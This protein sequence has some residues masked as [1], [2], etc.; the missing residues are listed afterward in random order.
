MQKIHANT[1]LIIAYDRGM[2]YITASKYM[3]PGANMKKWFQ[4]NIAPYKTALRY[5][6]FAAM[7]NNYPRLIVCGLAF[8]DIMCYHKLINGYIEEHTEFAAELRRHVSM[9]VGERLIDIDPC[10]KNAPVQTLNLSIILIWN[11]LKVMMMLL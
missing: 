10:P 9:R 3:P 1:G 4:D 7:V 6:A 2:F 8:S 11:I 5:M